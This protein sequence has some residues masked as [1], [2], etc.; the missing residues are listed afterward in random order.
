[1]SSNSV[2]SRSRSASDPGLPPFIP[3]LF[4]CPRRR[5]TITSTR[6]RKF[7]T[8]SKANKKITQSA[9]KELERLYI[10]PSG[11]LACHVQHILSPA[12]SGDYRCTIFNTLMVQPMAVRDSD[13]KKCLNLKHAPDHELGNKANSHRFYARSWT[14]TPSEL[15]RLARFMRSVGYSYQK[16]DNWEN[17]SRIFCRGLLTDRYVGV[18]HG[19]RGPC[20]RLADD[21]AG[22]PSKI[23]REKISLKLGLF[24]IWKEK[25]R[26]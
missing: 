3:G 9:R 17:A 6:E 25:S 10:D 5:N 16:L 22:K 20:H 2:L 12:Q 11:I 18:V 24:L 14:F 21:R 26:R 7:D 15:E 23:L 8:L 19:R 13:L 1:M 4:D